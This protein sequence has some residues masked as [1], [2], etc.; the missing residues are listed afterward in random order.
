LFIDLFFM[1]LASAASRQ[2]WKQATEKVN[3]QEEEDGWSDES[4]GED[5]DRIKL[6]VKT[7]NI[8]NAGDGL[9]L[10]SRHVEPGQTLLQVKEAWKLTSE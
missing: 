10:A 2:L 9:F 1:A 6:L 5:S 8:P 7:S 4:D 3:K